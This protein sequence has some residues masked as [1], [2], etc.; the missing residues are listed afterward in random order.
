M[1]HWIGIGNWQMTFSKEGEGKRLGHRSPW[2]IDAFIY[3]IGWRCFSFRIN[4]V[5][6]MNATNRSLVVVSCRSEWIVSNYRIELSYR[7]FIHAEYQSSR[8]TS[9]IGKIHFGIIESWHHYNA[10]QCNEMKYIIC[11]GFQYE[12][13]IQVRYPK[14]ETTTFCCV[15]VIGKE[16]EVKQW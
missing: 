3:L 13:L 7:W 2:S 11:N 8:R 1:R 10:M 14:G 12:K 15:L 4:I 5:Q 9:T 16:S 6:G